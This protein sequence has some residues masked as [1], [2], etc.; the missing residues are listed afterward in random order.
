MTSEFDKIFRRVLN[1]QEIFYVEQKIFN[2]DEWSK[3]REAL[4]QNKIQDIKN[5]IEEKNHPLCER[6]LGL[7]EK[8]PEIFR[9]MLEYLDCFEG[10]KCNL[11]NMDDYGKVIERYSQKTAELY[12]CDK[13]KREKDS[14]KRRA[15]ERVLNYV[16][17]L[18][19]ANLSPLEIAY[20]VRKLES[21]TIFREVSDEHTK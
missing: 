5:R 1:D 9:Q 21:L 3:L 13:I 12:F 17:E 15:L 16:K 8:C 18:Y 19:N 4:N 20:F 6:L 14:H 7:V 2:K 11:P 10:V